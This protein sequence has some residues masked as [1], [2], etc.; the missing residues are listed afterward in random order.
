VRAS[1]VF[2]LPV[3]RPHPCTA[4]ATV[5]SRNPACQRLLLGR[6]ALDLPLAETIAPSKAGVDKVIFPRKVLFVEPYDGFYLHPLLRRREP[7]IIEMQG[8]LRKF[9]LNTTVSS[10]GGRGVSLEID[11]S[12][13]R[14]SLS[15]SPVREGRP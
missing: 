12:K 5:F 8:V 6:W 3:L 14:I 7:Q 1:S 11:Y 4:L 15:S 9:P 13:V 10:S 2:S